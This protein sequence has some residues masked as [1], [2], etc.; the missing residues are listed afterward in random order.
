MP[1]LRFIYEGNTKKLQ[2]ANLITADKLI[3]NL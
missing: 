3:M 2:F 1:K